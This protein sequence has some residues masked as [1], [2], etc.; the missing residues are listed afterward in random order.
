[1]HF[2]S[3]IRHF[4]LLLSDFDSHIGDPF[5]P[6]RTTLDLLLSS[7][8]LFEMIESRLGYFYGSPNFLKMSFKFKT[9]TNDK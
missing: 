9:F 6:R 3:D 4:L 7:I 8:L 1:M 2:E 5:M